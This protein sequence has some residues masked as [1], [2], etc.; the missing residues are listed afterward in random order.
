MPCISRLY[1]VLLSVARACLRYYYCALIMNVL[2]ITLSI[3][4][5]SVHPSTFD[6]SSKTLAEIILRRR[7]VRFCPDTLSSS[8]RLPL[9]LSLSLIPECFALSLPVLRLM[10]SENVYHPLFLLLALCRALV[11]FSVSFRGVT[12]Q[13][14]EKLSPRFHPNVTDLTSRG[15]AARFPQI[16]ILL[17]YNSFNSRES[18]T[19]SGGGGGGGGWRVYAGGTPAF[20]LSRRP[21]GERFA[22]CFK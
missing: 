18:K 12:K 9:F 2:K 20:S 19:G 3:A 5:P 13:G 6:L 1:K 11:P 17:S 10:Q 14:V 21:S 22:L 15:D 4:S 7:R 16:I 8:L